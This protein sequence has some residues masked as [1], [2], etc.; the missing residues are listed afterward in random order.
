MSK[1]LEQHCKEKG[2]FFCA[3]TH[4]LDLAQEMIKTLP[5]FT[6]WAYIKHEADTEQGTPHYHFLIR[7]NGT[8]SVQQIADKLGIS[9]QYV[10]VCRKVV[11]FRRYMLHLDND[12]KI[13]Y[14]IDDIHTN[15]LPDFRSAILGNEQADVYELFKSFRSLASGAI[16]ADEFIQQNYIELQKMAFSQKIKTFDIILKTSHTTT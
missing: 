10:Q 5:D 9:P 4:D 8:R 12:E 16:T 6:S 11:A 7:N 3:V 15:R 2:S 1:R 14:T 13:K